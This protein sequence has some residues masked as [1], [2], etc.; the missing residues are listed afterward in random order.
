LNKTRRRIEITAFRRRVTVT[1]DVN[2]STECPPQCD[3]NRLGADTGLA[4][5]HAIQPPGTLAT[6]DVARSPEWR[7]L[8]EALFKNNG[9]TELAAQELHLT[10][11]SFYS[12]LRKLGLSIT[13]LRT[14]LNLVREKRDK[15]RKEN[16]EG[17]EGPLT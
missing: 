4:Q 17:N 3:D 6:I 12:K 16:R 15:R 1:G 5:V 8:V 13:N 10:R 9:D 14:N 7:T 2:G 11:S